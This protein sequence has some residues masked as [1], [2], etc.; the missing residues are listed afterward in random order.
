[1][2]L[3]FFAVFILSFLLLQWKRFSKQKWL[4]QIFTV[5]ALSFPVVV[6]VSLL[7]VFGAY[8]PYNPQAYGCLHSHLSNTSNLVLSRLSFPLYLEVEI[9]ATLYLYDGMSNRFFKVYFDGMLL[10]EM[11]YT[12]SSRLSY[13]FIH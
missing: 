13:I 2:F 12:Y 8:L 1:M 9:G 10:G 6:P 4:R 11:T 7:S 3:V 5:V